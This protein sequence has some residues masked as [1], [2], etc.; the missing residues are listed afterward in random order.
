MSHSFQIRSF[1]GGALQLGALTL[2]LG[3]AG[4]AAQPS[5]PPVAAAP[6]AE[7]FQR[8][9]GGGVTESQGNPEDMVFVEKE[10]KS[11]ASHDDAPATGLHMDQ[12]AHTNTKP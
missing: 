5:A 2:A 7:A 8:A 3:V 12:S 11:P 1:L 10:Q 4:C 6:P 9:A